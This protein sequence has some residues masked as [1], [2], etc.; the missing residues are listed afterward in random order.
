MNGTNLGT[1]KLTDTV[2]PILVDSDGYATLV[3]APSAIAVTTAGFQIGCLNVDTTIGKL[4]INTG[5][6]TTP[7]WTVVGSQT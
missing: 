1:A 5:N 4:Y 6:T 7:T 2:N 3:T